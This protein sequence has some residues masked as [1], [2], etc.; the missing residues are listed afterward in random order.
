MTR[1]EMFTAIIQKYGFEHPETIH[2]AEMMETE[3]SDAVLKEAMELALEKPFEE[4]D[5]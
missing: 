3:K 4:E 5:F 2:F 1:E